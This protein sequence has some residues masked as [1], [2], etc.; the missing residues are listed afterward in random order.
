MAL[1]VRSSVVDGQSEMRNETP[2]EED[3]RIIE[4]RV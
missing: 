2:Y 3:G 4:P 1:P